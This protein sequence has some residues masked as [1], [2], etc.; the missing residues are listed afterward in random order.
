MIKEDQVIWSITKTNTPSISKLELLNARLKFNLHEFVVQFIFQSGNGTRSRSNHQHC[1]F[2]TA[3]LSHDHTAWNRHRKE[4]HPSDCKV[5]K[6]CRK[7]SRKNLIDSYKQVFVDSFELAFQT[8][9]C[10]KTSKFLA[11][12]VC[13][14]TQKIKH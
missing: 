8:H 2:K 3:K 14:K 13:P 4:V 11:L 5:L 10:F 1:K 6:I 9:E 12:I 7:C